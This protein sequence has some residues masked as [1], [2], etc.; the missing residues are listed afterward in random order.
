MF[1]ML[2]KKKTTKKLPLAKKL[3]HY[4]F[5]AV[6]YARSHMAG[7][8]LKKGTWGSWWMAC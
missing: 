6:M 3:P 4:S 2:K 5:H 8:A 7:Q 1:C